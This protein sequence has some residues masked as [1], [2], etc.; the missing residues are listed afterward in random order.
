MNVEQV[1]DLE[2]AEERVLAEGHIM[3]HK[4]HV[5]SPGIKPGSPQLKALMSVLYSVH[6][7]SV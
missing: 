6:K 4:S 7:I 3:H 5:I 2:L 1:V